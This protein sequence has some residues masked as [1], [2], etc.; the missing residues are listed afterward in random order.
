MSVLTFPVMVP[1]ERDTAVLNL[2]LLSHKTLGCPAL[3][4][5][6]IS[7]SRSGRVVPT[8]MLLTFLNKF[9]WIKKTK[10]RPLPFTSGKY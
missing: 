10:S 6:H 8:S 3:L 4:A 2:W 7:M 5:F 1:K 9:Y